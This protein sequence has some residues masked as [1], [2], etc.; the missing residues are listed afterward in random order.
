MISDS[1]QIT[2]NIKNISQ[3]KDGYKSM[4]LDQLQVSANNL[5]ANTNELLHNSQQTLNQSIKK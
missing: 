1:K 4:D 3:D 5:I 2:S